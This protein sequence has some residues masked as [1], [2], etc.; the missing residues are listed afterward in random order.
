[1]A[2]LKQLYKKR[3]DLLNKK[4]LASANLAR[5]QEEMALHAPY[6]HQMTYDLMPSHIKEEFEYLE[7][8]KN[9]GRNGDTEI[10][11]IDGQPSHVTMPEANLLDS[12]GKA[13][14]PSIKNRGA[15]TIN[16][17]TGLKEYHG[18]HTDVQQ[19]VNT[20]TDHTGM[21]LNTDGWHFH[22]YGAYNPDG[23]DVWSVQP[24]NAGQSGANIGSGPAGWT[25]EGAEETYAEYGSLTEIGEKIAGVTGTTLGTADVQRYFGDIYKDEPYQFAREGADLKYRNLETQKKGF[26]I[27]Q[28]E[29]VRGTMSQADKMKAQSGF[30]RSGSIDYARD[31]A[32]KDIGKSTELGMEGFATEQAGIGLSLNQSLYDIKTSQDKAFWDRLGIAEQAGLL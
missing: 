28:A 13:A 3:K 20:T 6:L 10:R 19:D 29:Q 1:M 9:K 21:A 8:L 2:G 23:T 30:A 15:G 7:S 22:H 32:M 24:S 25:Q 11:S 12:L 18:E 4:A 16:P 27:K 17:D 5:M 26:Q 14:I 31:M